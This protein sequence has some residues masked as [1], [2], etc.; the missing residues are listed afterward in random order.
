MCVCP[1]FL[2]GL[3]VFACSLE[4][5]ATLTNAPECSNPEMAFLMRIAGRMNNY[6]AYVKPKL[7]FHL[8]VAWARAFAASISSIK[9]VPALLPSHGQC[10]EPFGAFDLLHAQTISS[11]LYRLTFTA[12]PG[13]HYH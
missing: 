3:R 1:L 5:D 8:S 9:C 10:R 4:S 12:D 7:L 11:D 6:R 13:D 2:R